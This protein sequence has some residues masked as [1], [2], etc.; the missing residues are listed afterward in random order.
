MNTPA[1]LGLYGLCLVAAFGAAFAVSAAIVP[2]ELAA[3]RAAA[4]E[5]AHGE[6]HS[7]STEDAAAGA[8]TEALLP[9]LSLSQGGFTLQPIEAPHAAGDKGTL[10]FIIVDEAGEPLIEYEV[11]HEKEL[12][13]IVVRSDGSQFKHVHP[14]MDE[15][16]TWSTPWEW[17]EGGSYR[18]FTD[19]TPHGAEGGITLGRTV[20]VDGEFEAV[21]ATPEERTSEIDGYIA[22]LVGDLSAGG[23][24]TLTVEISKDGKPV[25]NIEPYLGAFG[26]LVALRDGDLAYLHVHPTGTEPEAGEL[27]GPEVSFATEAPT[28]GRYLLYFD[29]QVEGKTHSA[30]FVLTTGEGS[31]DATASHDDEEAAH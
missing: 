4:V 1:R 11:E 3:E 24:S 20:L 18:V 23:E 17:A 22:T 5:G 2:P 28:S 27:S 7:S 31:G 8:M 29:F 30:A 26:H 10:E 9:G 21:H 12:H 16:G 25:T 13:L 14:T 6:G 19:F 15:H